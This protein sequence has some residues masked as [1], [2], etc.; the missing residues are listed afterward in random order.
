MN[1]EEHEEEHTVLVVDDDGPVLNVAS[2]ALDRAGYRVLSAQGGEDALRTAKEFDGKIDLLLTDVVMPAMGG[3][4]LAERFIEV[5]PDTAV[6][7]MSAYTED[8]VILK[9]VRVA[10][11]SFLSKPF[12][13]ADLSNA[14]KAALKSARGVG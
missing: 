10:S 7:F 1:E 6:L 9:G 13:L 11:V 8:E 14:V 4:E 2:R 5:R 3:R 12:T